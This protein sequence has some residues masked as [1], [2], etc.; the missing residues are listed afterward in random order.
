MRINERHI[1]RAAVETNLAGSS[2]M[3][4]IAVSVATAMLA[5]ILMGGFSSARA[6]S[7]LWYTGGIVSGG[8]SG[9]N[10]K[11]AF[12]ALAATNPGGNAW[13]ITYW[14]SGPVPAPLSSYNVLVVASQT[15]F[16]NGNPDYSAL[17]GSGL[18]EASFGARVMATGLDADWHYLNHPGPSNFDGPKG[19][20]ID[21]I[22]WS[23]SGSGT[24][25]V[26]LNDNAGFGFFS[27]LGTLYDLGGA[28]DVRIPS[29]YTGLPMN[30]GLTSLG[31]SNWASS[32]HQEWVGSDLAKWA[33]IEVYGSSC[34]SGSVNPPVGSC[35]GYVTLVKAAAIPEPS[36]FGLVGTGVLALGAWRKRRNVQD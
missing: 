24:G 8:E 34:S 16:W 14:D 31:L 27:G 7:I 22:N 4:R 29:E 12:N 21:A 35:T 23:G 5:V 10:Y 30:A 20:L 15:G 6:I 26:L 19:F 33:P 32:F 13:A 18:N 3:R 2:A 28:E 11:S 17:T 25:A 9:T 1:V 36:T